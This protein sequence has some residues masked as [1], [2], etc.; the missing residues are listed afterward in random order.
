MSSIL[1]AGALAAILAALAGCGGEPDSA[2]H[3]TP[4]PSPY[5][6]DDPT[7]PQAS[8]D[9][10]AARAA[11]SQAFEVA[12][13]VDV[14]AIVAFYEAMMEKADEAC[15]IVSADETDTTR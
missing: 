10:D 8:L 4:D 7:P 3:P 14:P 13:E 9:R 15:P 1:R 12:R 5:L 6:G 2:E 11:V